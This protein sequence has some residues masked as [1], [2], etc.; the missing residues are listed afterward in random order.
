[1]R[2]SAWIVELPPAEFRKIKEEYMT[3]HTHD[4]M[5]KY[6]IWSD[7]CK[8]I[9]WPKLSKQYSKV[10]PDLF[11][12]IY[13]KIRLMREK[14]GLLVKESKLLPGYSLKDRL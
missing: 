14:E 12:P 3:T 13:E 5:A 10:D 8:K 4:F 1:M 6:S 2:A 11:Q 7:L 9:F